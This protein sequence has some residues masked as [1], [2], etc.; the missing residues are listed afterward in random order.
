MNKKFIITVC[1]VLVLTLL[2]VGGVLLYFVQKLPIEI[3][4]QEYIKY[5][6]LA[7]WPGYDF[8]GAIEEAHRIII[9]TV[10]EKSGT[11]YDEIYDEDL[12]K[13]LFRQYYRDVTIEVERV[14]KGDT[15]LE[16]V[17]Y[18]EQG[19]ETIKINEDGTF[20]IY[21]YAEGYPK[22][23]VGDRVLLFLSENNVYLNPSTLFVIEPDDTISVSSDL[24]TSNTM[25]KSQSHYMET[26]DLEEYIAAIEDYL[27][28]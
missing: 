15:D 14:I 13:L 24:L 11:K 1:S 8:E 21:D 25:R 2:V 16:T 6:N 18:K 10:A 12:G 23:D 26:Y 5:P 19:G 28:S 9:G 27:A 4:V 17:N 3:P 20:S 22:L 7:L